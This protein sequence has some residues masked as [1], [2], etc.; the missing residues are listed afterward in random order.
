MLNNRSPEKNALIIFTKENASA[1]R[2]YVEETLQYQDVFDCFYMLPVS[3]SLANKSLD[4]FLENTAISFKDT[5]IYLIEKKRPSEWSVQHKYDQSILTFAKKF[6]KHFIAITYEYF[7]G[8]QKDEQLITFRKHHRYTS[9]NGFS[10]GTAGQVPLLKSRTI[11]G[12]VKTLVN[13]SFLGIKDRC[14]TPPYQYLLSDGIGSELKCPKALDEIEKIKYRK[15]I[16]TRIAFRQE[17]VDPI[18]RC[19]EH[20]YR[21]PESVAEKLG[22]L[23]HAYVHCGLVSKRSHKEFAGFLAECLYEKD[24]W[25][26]EDCFGFIKSEIDKYPD[27]INPRGTFHGLKL[28]ILKMLHDRNRWQTGDQLKECLVDKYKLLAGLKVTHPSLDKYIEEVLI[29]LQNLEKAY[30]PRAVILRVVDAAIDIIQNTSAV[31]NQA[32][33]QLTSEAGVLSTPLP[34]FLSGLWKQPIQRKME[35]LSAVNILQVKPN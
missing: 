19:A 21:D 25:D 31:N 14:E 26:I 11:G 12:S 18:V 32:Y 29:E 28:E 34:L 33:R 27:K 2:G 4:A 5:P 6:K 30:K 20:D 35:A 1:A 24:D 10:H 22:N 3:E 8:E 9:S 15:A 23:F 17:K 16:E 7:A 13:L